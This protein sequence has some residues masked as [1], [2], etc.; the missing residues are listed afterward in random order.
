[1]GVIYSLATLNPLWSLT[2]YANTA[3]K[4]GFES[5]WQLNQPARPL[6]RRRVVIPHR[7]Q[8]CRK[9][10]N[11]VLFLL[12]FPQTHHMAD[13]VKHLVKERILH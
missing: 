13:G 5:C 9:A 11:E 8:S 1:M 10:A 12:G 4:S 2:S 6:E 7:A 3:A